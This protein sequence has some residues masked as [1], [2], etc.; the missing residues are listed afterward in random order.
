MADPGGHAH[1][2]RPETSDE[3]FYSA[4]ETY[5]TQDELAESGCDNANKP[6]AALGVSALDSAEASAPTPP[7]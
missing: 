3:L 5:I 2:K 1:T 7:L 4:K 6:F